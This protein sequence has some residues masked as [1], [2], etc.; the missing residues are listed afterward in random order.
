M[1]TMK[2][3]KRYLPKSISKKD[4]NKQMKMLLKSRK[5]YKKGIY[6]TRKHLS[7][8]KSKTSSHIK[9][10]LKIYKVPVIDATNELSHASGCSKNTLKKIIRKGEGAYFSSGS[11][12]NQTA[13]S[14]GKARL[15]S[16]LTSG[17][18]ATVDYDILEKGCKTNSKALIMAKKA[19]EKYGY[20][21]RK[22]PKTNI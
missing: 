9:N 10:A 12:P 18:A 14:W 8:Y 6:Y 17:K 21:R 20:G 3:N 19:R 7:S 16:S 4:R 2:I 22:S 5:Q 1:K 11:R 13:Q 15:A